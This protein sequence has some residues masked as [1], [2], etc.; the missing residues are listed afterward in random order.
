M[1]DRTTFGGKLRAAA[2]AAMAVIVLAGCRTT[3][4]VP[5]DP[6]APTEGPGLVRVLPGEPMPD[7]LAAYGR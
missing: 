6:F 7:V 4:E 1:M 2:L 5:S 3:K